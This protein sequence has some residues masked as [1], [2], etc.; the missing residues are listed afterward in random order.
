MKLIVALSAPAII[1]LSSWALAWAL[2]FAPLR[3][4]TY[5]FHAQLTFGLIFAV[6]TWIGPFAA[7]C[8]TAA[9]YK[10]SLTLR[11]RFALYLLNGAWGVASLGILIH[12]WLAHRG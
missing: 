6:M 4:A 10:S 7:I 2:A 5:A 1:G 3:R 8:A 12:F 11:R 9:I